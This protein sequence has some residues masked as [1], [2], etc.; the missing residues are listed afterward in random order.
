MNVTLGADP[1]IAVVNNT[2]GKIV[3]AWEITK[4][5]KL[6]EKQRLNRSTSIHADGV[7]LEYNFDPV[8]IDQFIQAHRV[9]L[10]A[11]SD[12]LSANDCSYIIRPEINGWS[13]DAL[14]HPLATETGCSE[15]YDAYAEET[16]KPR[17]K[18]KLEGES[19]F[20]G[21]HIHIGYD[22]AIPPWAMV[23]LLD[24]FAYLP[25]LKTD[26]QMGRV[27]LYGL[28][29]LFRPKP[30]GVEYRTPSNFW[31]QGRTSQQIFFANIRGLFNA[32]ENHLPEVNAWFKD[33]N[34]EE[35]REVM[36]S[37]DS[38]NLSRWWKGNAGK[39]ATAWKMGTMAAF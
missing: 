33:T 36:T 22:G 27:K 10:S 35:V 25:I 39:M 16:D 4:G 18:V 5:I 37:R 1:E 32:L 20:F 31:V 28:P 19:R 3:P 38:K 26:N 24:V 17:P 30:Y 14:L 8:P 15:D 21:G 23:R 6:G 29:G 9:A 2:T 7:A 12:F 11:V 13:K 34:W